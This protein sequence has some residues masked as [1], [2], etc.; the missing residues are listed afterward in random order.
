MRTYLE[1]AIS[2]SSEI[3]EDVENFEHRE[4]EERRSAARIMVG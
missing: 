2:D 1:N 4:S 3:Y